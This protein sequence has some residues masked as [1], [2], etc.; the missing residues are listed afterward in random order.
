[1][2]IL[3]SIAPAGCLF[4]GFLSAG[5]RSACDLSLVGGSPYG[6]STEGELR[7]RVVFVRPTAALCCVAEPAY[8]IKLSGTV[9]PDLLDAS[10]LELPWLPV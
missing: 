6:P 2:S 4:T 3:V 9:L 10:G 8:S 1:M 5:A 7:S